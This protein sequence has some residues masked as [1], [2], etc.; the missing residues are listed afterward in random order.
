MTTSL[1]PEP[2]L[3]QIPLTYAEKIEK[4]E[5]GIEKLESMRQLQNCHNPRRVKACYQV[6]IGTRIQLIDL[7]MNNKNYLYARGHVVK[8]RKFA[9]E[10]G[11]Q[12]AW[13]KC[14]QLLAKINQGAMVR[15]SKL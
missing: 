3:R 6:E 7:L 14:Q 13:K 10:I 8:L 2:W 1:S 5:D 11:D 15:I 9:L 4:L 12:P